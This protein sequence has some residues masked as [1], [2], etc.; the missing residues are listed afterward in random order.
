VWQTR[1]FNKLAG[2]LKCISLMRRQKTGDQSAD[3][4]H[5]LRVADHISF[6]VKALFNWG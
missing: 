3:T 2:R 6:L 4:V 1:P 5:L